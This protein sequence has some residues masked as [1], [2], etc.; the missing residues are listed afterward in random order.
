MA[1]LP[2]AL[3][4]F[5]RMWRTGHYQ[6]FPLVMVVIGWLWYQTTD[7]LESHSETPNSRVFSILMLGVMVLVAVATVLNTSFVGAVSMAFLFATALYGFYGLSGFKR[8]LPLVFLTLFIV[9]LPARLDTILIFNLQFLASQLASWILDVFGQTHFREGVILQTET[10][11]F[12]T[13]EACSGIRSLFSSLAGIAIYGVT[14]GYRWPRHLFNLTQTLIWVVVGNAIR[15][16]TVVVVSE[17][18]SDR[19]ASGRPH[20]I[21]GLVTFL[22]IFLL[23]ISTDRLYGAFAK[24]DEGEESDEEGA[25]GEADSDLVSRSNSKEHFQ[26]ASWLGWVVLT[27]AALVLLVGARIAYVQTMN[28]QGIAL[29]S[30]DRLPFP[31]QTNLPERIGGWSQVSFEHTNRGKENL[32]AEDSFIWTFE[33]QGLTALISVDCPWEDWHN[34][35]NC[36]SGLGW[37]THIRHFF[38]GQDSLEVGADMPETNFSQ[39]GMRKNSGETGVVIFSSVDANANMVTPQFSGGYISIESAWK[40]VVM[41]LYRAL[42]VSREKSAGVQGY[43]LPLSTFQL[44]CT[45]ET[46]VTQDQMRSLRLLFVDARKLLKESPRFK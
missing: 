1:H 26:P 16:A 44:L 11:G 13:E 5:V 41:N 36:Y 29:Y 43:K 15:I 40:Q 34:L 3:E 32:Q 45:P 8:G 18:Y 9:P 19:I 6:F 33:N 2:I 39:I 42:G 30:Y 17:H 25:S 12:L 35:D 27:L 23:A 46:E 10:R 20:E 21:L 4:Y 31:D 37:G 22:L 28:N 38:A 7:Q 24:E 14:M